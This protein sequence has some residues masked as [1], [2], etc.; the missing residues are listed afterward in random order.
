M[1]VKSNN[2][3]I[4]SIDGMRAIAVISVLLFHVDFEWATGGFTGVDVF[5]VISGFL[6]TRNIIHEVN[7]ETWTFGNFYLRRVTR[8]FPALFATIILTLFAAWW[9]LSPADLERIGQTSIMSVLSVGNIFFWLEAGYF[10]ANSSTK[11]L[12]HTW[13]LAVEEQ[14]YLVWPGALLLLLT[15]GRKIALVGVA[16]AG[17]LSLIA[18]F[19]YLATDPSAVFFLTPFRIHQ[20][21]IGAI[22][23]LIGW[24]PNGRLSSV[25]SA[26]AVLGLAVVT[27]SAS[28]SSPY[29]F[30]AVFPAFC[31]GLLLLSSRSEFANY[32]LSTPIMTWVG[33]RSYSIY[34][35]H[36]PVI[37]LWKLKTDLEFSLFEQVIAVFLSILVGVVLFELVENLYRFKPTHSSARKGRSILASV[38]LGVAAL[39]IGAH[40]WGN[41]GYESRIPEELRNVLADGDAVWAKRQLAVRDGICSHTTTS[42]RAEN[43]DQMRCSSPPAEGRSYLVVGDSFANDATLVLKSAYPS[44]YFGQLTVPGCLLRLPKQFDPGE[45]VECR[46]LYKLAFEELLND[47]GYDGVVLSSNWQDGHYYRINDIINSLQRRDLDIVVIGQRVRFRD[48][49][50]AIVTSSESMLDAITKANRLVL[51]EQFKINST[52]IER[53]SGRAKVLDF[54]ALSCPDACDVFDQDGNLVYMDDSHFSLAGIELIAARLKQQRSEL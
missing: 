13:S 26:F 37:V 49:V 16:M 44:I 40:Y 12:L 39:T 35:A 19:Y 46:K 2:R 10:D 54:M 7:E 34:L 36:W 38:V 18:A 42:A 28:N 15:A 14:F 1:T 48:R 45:Q 50:P 17:A 43:F 23:A 8:L 52:I 24:L 5:F 30:S 31:A 51:Q 4:S 41:Q 9:I 32:A 53:F 3:Y 11:P 27:V 6:I 33:R 20:F 29:F 47:E 25:S 21:A 22:I